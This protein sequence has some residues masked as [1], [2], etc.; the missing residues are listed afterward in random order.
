MLSMTT[1]PVEL[2][3]VTVRWELEKPKTAA[4]ERRR[5]P[6]HTSSSSQL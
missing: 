3:F 6:W 2:V 1:N 5:W 4:A